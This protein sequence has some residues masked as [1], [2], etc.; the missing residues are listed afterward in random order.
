MLLLNNLDKLLN[1]P[2][3]EMDGELTM[4]ADDLRLFNRKRFQLKEESSHGTV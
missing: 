2:V 1:N 4:F 3:E